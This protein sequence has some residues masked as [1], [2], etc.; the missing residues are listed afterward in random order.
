MVSNNVIYSSLDRA[1]FDELLAEA[2]Y[3]YP[4]RDERAMY[5]DLLASGAVRFAVLEIGRRLVQKNVL[6]RAEVRMLLS[7]KILELVLTCFATKLA[8]SA[9]D[10]ELVLMMTK[11]SNDHSAL[12]S[13]LQEWEE[14][15]DTIDPDTVPE[16]LGGVPADP[17]PADW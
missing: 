7:G 4:L 11:P 15:R 17:P 12:A 2:Q 8:L 14:Y 6:S 1:L 16:F 5:C 3:L 10:E 13:Q 9:S